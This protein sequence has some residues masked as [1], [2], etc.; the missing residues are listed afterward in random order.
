M[1]LERARRVATWHATI[2]WLTALAQLAARLVTVYWQLGDGARDPVLLAQ[3]LLKSGLLIVAVAVYRRRLWP[4]HLLLAVWPVG[5]VYAAAVQ[6]VPPAVLALGLLTGVGYLL[7]ARGM[8][9][10]RALDRRHAPAAAVRRGVAA[11]GASRIA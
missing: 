4:S 7:G 2:G 10:L 1:D 3:A 11:E 8:R 6:R 9:T 5:F